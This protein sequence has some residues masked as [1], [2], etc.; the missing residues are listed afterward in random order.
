MSKG[1]WIQ[2]QRA[3]RVRGHY[4]GL[5]GCLGRELEAE[6]GG[7]LGLRV[8]W[9]QGLREEVA[10]WGDEGRGWEREGTRSQITEEAK[11]LSRLESLGSKGEGARES[12][13]WMRG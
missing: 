10:R 5:G 1:P 7:S 6:S 12:G 4:W 11:G 8:R 2:S 9:T 13:D 3:W